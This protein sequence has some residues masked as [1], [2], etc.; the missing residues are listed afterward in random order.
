MKSLTTFPLFLSIL[1]AGNRL[2]RTLVCMSSQSSTWVSWNRGEVLTSTLSTKKAVSIEQF[3][4]RICE[5]AGKR[6]VTSR[7]V[8]TDEQPFSRLVH[9]REWYL[10]Q[11]Q[12]CSRNGRNG[13][14]AR[15]SL[16]VV[17]KRYEEALNIQEWVVQPWRWSNSTAP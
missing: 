1:S 12:G 9:C 2:R 15:L 5:V 4:R 14:R 11:G 17:L 6:D 7:F 16:E 10:L 8:G 3:E 13:C